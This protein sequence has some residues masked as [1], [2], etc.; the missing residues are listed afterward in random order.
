MKKHKWQ[1]ALIAISVIAL[2]GLTGGCLTVTVPDESAPPPPASQEPA[3]PPATPG[4]AT[5]QPVIKSFTASPE[6][7]TSGQSVTLR[8]DVS[9]ATTVTIHP[10]VGTVSQSSS[11]QVSPTNTTTYILTARTGADSSTSSVT[12][13][14]TSSLTGR[15]D[16]IITDIQLTGTMVYYKIKNQG[17]VNAKPSRTYLYI[18]GIKVGSDYVEP[19]A[20]GQEKTESFSNYQYTGMADSIVTVKICA[21]VDDEIAESDEDN[22]CGVANWGLLF[23]YDFVKNA[24]L[25]SWSSGAGELKLP[26][27]S[28]NKKGAAFVR[29]NSIVMCTEQV[30]YGWIQGRFAD[31]YTDRYRQLQ[32]RKIVVPEKTKF[33]AK[34]SLTG[35]ATAADGV[36]IALGYI[37]NTGSVVLFP[38]MDV[39]YGEEAKVYQIDLS[40]MASEKTEFVLRVEAKDSSKQL[41]LRWE[42]PKI[43]QEP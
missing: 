7:I 32:S 43:I 23:S 40:D 14:V 25:A 20:V 13:T 35:E 3:T 15:P 18:N 19:V 12:V 31:Y 34:V 6:T 39:H 41:C 30:R 11:A 28:G 1:W 33:T 36:R 24:H 2:I 29:V 38:K 42:K 16:L 9:A 37:D 22:N 21:D 4:G 8:W 5:D 10:V 26:L 17:D 27:P